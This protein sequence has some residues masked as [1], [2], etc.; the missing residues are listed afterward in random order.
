M[1]TKTAT[2]TA[3]ENA[4]IAAGISRKALSDASGIAWTTLNRKLGGYA[5]SV[6]FTVTEIEALARV[7]GVEPSELVVFAEKAA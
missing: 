3:I 1:D 4:R 7:L 2:A 5:A 6:A